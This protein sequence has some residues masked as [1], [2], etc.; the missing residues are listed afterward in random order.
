MSLSRRFDVSMTFLL[1]RTPT[2]WGQSVGQYQHWGALKPANI[3]DWGN[4]IFYTSA[5]LNT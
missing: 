4:S 5:S 3:A 2:G 1:H